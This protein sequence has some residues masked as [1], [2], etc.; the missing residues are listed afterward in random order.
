[1]ESNLPWR[2]C[3]TSSFLLGVGWGV[4]CQVPSTEALCSHRTTVT[5]RTSSNTVDNL[6]NEERA[7]QKGHRVLKVGTPLEG[8][9]LEG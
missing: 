7:V 1:M 4:F 3:G 5:E 8:H 9:G 2:L 6:S